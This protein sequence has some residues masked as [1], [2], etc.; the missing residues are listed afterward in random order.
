[1]YLISI[2]AIL[3]IFEFSGLLSPPVQGFGFGNPG[4]IVKRGFQP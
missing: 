1:M 3:M 4:P 2:H